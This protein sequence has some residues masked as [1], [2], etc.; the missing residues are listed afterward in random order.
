MTQTH[1]GQVAIVTG[2][3]QGIGR[4]ICEKLSQ[5][6]ATVILVDLNDPSR[7]LNALDGEAMK[8]TADVS[9]PDDWKRVTEQVMDTYGRID[10]LVNNAG[11]MPWLP[12]EETSL[13]VW[14]QA[15]GVNIDAHFHSAK[16]IVPIMRQQQF[17]RI[18]NISSNSVGTPIPG[19]SAY[20][21]SKMAVV[22]F[23][24]GLS[25]DVANDGITV[26]AV[27]PAFTNTPGTAAA[28]E[29]MRVGVMAAQAIKRIAQPDDIA[30]PV[31][32]L[33]SEEARF[34]TGQVLVADGGMYKIS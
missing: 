24:R 6:G 27:M 4:A 28:P 13:E 14:R 31:V 9:S 3:G 21:A 5:R 2:A 15:F 29:T 30:G 33:T 10:I 25:N 32:F 8:I 26:N 22:G 11:I 20:M 19:F 34:V 23:V 12:F 18:V 1:E 7:A 16:E 17:G